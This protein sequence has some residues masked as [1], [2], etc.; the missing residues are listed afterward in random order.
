MPS[1]ASTLEVL[2]PM[3]LKGEEMPTHAT[4]LEGAGMVASP[5]PTLAPT[6]EVA[7]PI[8]LNLK[9]EEMPTHATTTLEGSDSDAAACP[10]TTNSLKL[11]N[12]TTNTGMDSPKTST[13]PTKM[14]AAEMPS[15]PG[16][17]AETSTCPMLLPTRSRAT[18]SAWLP[19]RLLRPPHRRVPHVSPALL[20]EQRGRG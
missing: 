1:L 19:H 13:R 18:P 14:N 8:T 20:R 6:L 10:T 15:R 9:G 12:P 4:T 3:T 2:S 16:M 17:C 11:M 7:S 5:M